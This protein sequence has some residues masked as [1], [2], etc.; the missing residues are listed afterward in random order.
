MKLHL[1]PYTIHYHRCNTINTG[2]LWISKHPNPHN[3]T[4]KTS[5]SKKKTIIKSKMHYIRFS[6][7]QKKNNNNHISFSIK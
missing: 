4:Y 7:V 6:P 1:D 2:P 3:N 5:E